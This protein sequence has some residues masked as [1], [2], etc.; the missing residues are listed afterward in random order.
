MEYLK[1]QLTVGSSGTDYGYSGTPGFGSINGGQLWGHAVIS[2]LA[3][4]IA[5]N[6]ITLDF[7]QQVNGWENL[8]LII[9]D[10]SYIFIWV[11]GNGT[12]E[13]EGSPAPIAFIKAN[14]GSTIDIGFPDDEVAAPAVDAFLG[15][16]PVSRVMLGDKLVGTRQV[17]HSTNIVLLRFV[18]HGLDVFDKNMAWIGRVAAQGSPTSA[19]TSTIIHGNTCYVS[20]FAV[21]GNNGSTIWKFDLT[22]LQVTVLHTFSGAEHYMTIEYFAPSNTLLS[23][24][25]SYTAHTNP[26]N[27]KIYAIDPDVGGITAQLDSVPMNNPMA[28][29]N[30]LKAGGDSD[31]CLIVTDTKLY[32]LDVGSMTYALK[33]TLSTVINAAYSSSEDWALLRPNAAPHIALD[34]KTGTEYSIPFAGVYAPSTFWGNKA[35]VVTGSA[36]IFY[37]FVT[38]VGPMIIRETAYAGNSNTNVSVTHGKELIRVVAPASG[39]RYP[40]VVSRIDLITGVSTQLASTGTVD[41]YFWSSSLRG[42]SMIARR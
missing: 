24:P 40:L 39:N 2:F 17:Q 12:Y 16:V 29:S 21:G 6:V 23:F 20:S 36:Y 26:S 8:E 14:N 25:A 3:S 4:D 13:L 38:G 37:R 7:G 1:M 15:D 11:S 27:Q 41:E 5:P 33:Y 18:D 10:I 19:T 30:I 28:R 35:I 32:S 42:P 34:L 9:D 31:E 22:S